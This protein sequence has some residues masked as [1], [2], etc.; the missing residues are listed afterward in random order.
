MIFKNLKISDNDD[1]F[2]LIEI[3]LAITII[4]IAVVTLLSLSANSIT[5]I[6]QLKYR[7]EALKIAEMTIE[8]F[9]ARAIV[10]WITFTTDTPI[11]FNT[12]NLEESENFLTEVDFLSN[13]YTV[14]VEVLQKDIDNDTILDDD[15]YLINVTVSWNYS[16]I[17]LESFINKR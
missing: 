9:K 17:K 16:N 15:I 12:D 8:E 5:F 6:S 11:V 1:G 3:I 7:S 4:S 13:E 2:T 14:N 10:D